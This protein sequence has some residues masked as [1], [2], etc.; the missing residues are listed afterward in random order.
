MN[1]GDEVIAPDDPH[2]GPAGANPAAGVA[3]VQ[4]MSQECFGFRNEMPPTG[5]EPV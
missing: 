3:R 4:D 1:A 5:F 2:L